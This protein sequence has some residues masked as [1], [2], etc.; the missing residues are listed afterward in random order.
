MPLAPHVA[1]ARRN[2]ELLLSALLPKDMIRELRKKSTATGSRETRILEAGASRLCPSHNPYGLR[3]PTIVQP[4]RE[5]LNFPL[6]V[7]CLASQTCLSCHVSFCRLNSE[8][9]ADLLLCMLGQLLEGR[10]PDLRDVVFI[11]TALLRNLDVYSP[12]NLRSHIKSA[13][14]DVGL[15]GPA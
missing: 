6:A 8:T 4:R 7:L 2:H 14:L 3:L 13:N 10:T 1:L 9:P 11:R 15:S 5:A 12:L